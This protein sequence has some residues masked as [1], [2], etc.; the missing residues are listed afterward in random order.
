MVTQDT[1]SS[2]CSERHDRVFAWPS[3]NRRSG[4]SDHEENKK[5]PRGIRP[6][7]FPPSP[8]GAKYIT[9]TQ[10]TIPN[11]CSGRHVEYLFGRE[12]TGGLKQVTTRKKR[13]EKWVLKEPV[14]TARLKEHEKETGITRSCPDGGVNS[15]NRIFCGSTGQ[16]NPLG[17]LWKHKRNLKI[18]SHR[19]VIHNLFRCSPNTLSVALWSEL[20]QLSLNRGYDKQR[21]NNRVRPEYLQGK[22][23]IKSHIKLVA[24]SAGW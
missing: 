9:V 13:W 8:Q 12:K 15:L 18:T 4:A 20:Y 23:L 5:S 17:I 21:F 14:L 22:I 3:E 6:R 24:V 1:S 2:L 10:D 7:R 19:R 11:L 16:I